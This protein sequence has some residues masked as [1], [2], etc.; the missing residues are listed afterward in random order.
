MRITDLLALSHVPRWCNVAISRPQSV[1]D[2]TFRVSAI[3]LELCDRLHRDPTLKG[4]TWANVH[5][6]P[7]A[8]TGD[9]PGDFKS[10]A[11]GDLREAERKSTPWWSRDLEPTEQDKRLVKLADKIETYTYIL[12]FGVGPHAERVAGL[13][14]EQLKELAGEE[15]P[16]VR[17]ICN[18]IHEETDRN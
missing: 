17:L 3:Y 14:R 11:L 1:A 15:W 4:L 18:D 7:E 8:N 2:H 6:G 9:I 16:T 10:Q 13:C 5:D 12:K